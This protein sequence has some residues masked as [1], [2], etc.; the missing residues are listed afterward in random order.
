MAEWFEK[1]FD[2]L[3]GQVL[4][5]QFDEQTS[6]EQARLVKR[7]LRVRRGS[8][9]LDVPCGM[10]RLTI[11]MAKMGL[12]MTGVDLTERYIQRARRDARQHEVKARF[13]CCDTREI[14]SSASS[15]RR[16]TGS[17]ASATSA[18]DTILTSA[19]VC[20]VR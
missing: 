3:Y 11:P 7:L 5:R 18:K 17:G 13:V 1:F 20:C 12:V 19:G 9:V 14:D 4:A 8:R 6:L 2:G 15:T 16:S 10:G